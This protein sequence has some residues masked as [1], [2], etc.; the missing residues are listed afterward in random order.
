MIY[1]DIISKENGDYS[2][3]YKGN[4]HI[5][6]TKR[7]INYKAMPLTITTTNSNNIDIYLRK[8]FTSVEYC[9]NYKGDGSDTWTSAAVNYSTD[10]CRI[11]LNTNES[12]SIRAI[13]TNNRSASVTANDDFCIIGTNPD[14]N[15]ILSGNV[16]S[17]LNKTSYPS[18]L[19]NY[20][21]YTFRRLFTLNDN[22][23]R[24]RNYV[25]DIDNLVLTLPNSEG[26]FYEMFS[27]N[28][29]HNIPKQLFMRHLPELYPVL[30]YSSYS[31]KYMFQYQ[32][33]NVI[34]TF[35][36]DPTTRF[37]T[38]EDSNGGTG[39]MT[40]MFRGCKI[41]EL[42]EDLFMK[43]EDTLLGGGYA[44]IPIGEEAYF[45]MFEGCTFVNPVIP[46]RLLACTFHYSQQT[47]GLREIYGYGLS[48]M[49]GTTNITTAPS[50]PASHLGSFCYLGM[51]H[52]CTSLTTVP[53]VLPATN[54]NGYLDTGCYNSMFR[55]CTSLTTAPEL[56]A[57]TLSEYCCQYMFYGCSNLTSISCRATD[58]SATNCT[59]QWVSGVANS[60]TF[61]K[62][63]SMQNWTRGNDGIPSGWTVTN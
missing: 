8:G 46:A 63:S 10:V 52:N 18:Y 40:G 30:S 16:G 28:K 22:N 47:S 44:Y 59:N 17:L 13:W 55:S 19:T 41:A 38:L 7:Q 24:T 53:N 11:P 48:Y 4:Q 35:E 56:P 42:P 31:C 43:Y 39:T 23:T 25:Y 37:G 36:S 57:R 27:H 6:T 5:M 29:V 12:V 58:I 26:C 51:F 50:L 1:C 60:G 15:L 34:M 3:L 49:F 20:G 54:S 21:T 9:K 32:D 62:A 45:R 14:A 33:N 61:K 2:E